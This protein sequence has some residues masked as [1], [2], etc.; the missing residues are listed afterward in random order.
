MRILIRPRWPLLTLALLAPSIPE[1]LTGSTPVSRLLYDPVGFAVSYAFDVGLY[2][3]GALLVREAAVAFRKGWASIVLWGAAYG[4]AEEGLA[5]HTFFERSGPPVG[6]LTV[7]GSAY[8]VDWLWALG[9]TV[10]HAT[11][12]IALPILLTYLWFPEASKRRWLDGGG[13]AIVAAVYLAVVAVFAFLVGHGPSPALLGLFL[14]IEAGLLGAG[15]AAPERLLRVR[16][17]AR[18]VGRWGIAGAGCLE[19][20]AWLIVLVLSHGERVPAWGAAAVIAGANGAALAVVLWG[21]GSDDLDRSKFAFAVG[22][23]APL[24]LWDAALE[25][26]IPGLVGVALVFAYLLVRLGGVVD[27]RALSAQASG[28]PVLPERPS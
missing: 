27:R 3:T 5:V 9:L 21:V 4:V 14:A 13:V 7:Y 22:M 8:G 25:F 26:T 17:G 24:F 1:L 18:R 20:A 6:S 28:G 19:W 2:G 12:S 10:F 15:F 23:L 16:S 11:Y